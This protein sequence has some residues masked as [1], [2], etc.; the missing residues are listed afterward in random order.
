M[1]EHISSGKYR[2]WAG[3]MLFAL[4]L[5]WMAVPASAQESGSILGTV[6]DASG[7]TVPAAKITVTNADTNE[8]RTAN[9]G[10]DGAYR[11]PGLKP[12]NYTLKAE[13]D[14]FKTVT[15]MSLVLNVAS[16]IVVNPTMEVGSSTQEVTVTGEAPVINTTTS[17]L[18]NLINDQ[19][20]SQLPM[21]GRNYTDLTLLSPGIVQTTHSGLGDAGLWYSSN[22]APPRS[23]NYMLDGAVTVT[24]NGTGPSS[25][26]GATLGVD[27]IKEYKVVTSMFSAEYGLLMGS[28]MVIVSKS[29]TNTWHGSAFDYL[30]NNHLDARNFFDPQP[31]R[32]ESYFDRCQ[33]QPAALA[34][35]QAQQL[36]RLARRTHPE[37]QDVLLPGV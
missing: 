25:I 10:D 5:G 28:Q 27:G 11:V 35:I 16:E 17:S 2:M 30:R 8:T 34:A 19:T 12:G 9:T 36:R 22:G 14:G 3:V 6:R 24:K 7:G 31:N 4:I 32:S 13:K 18:G 37:G 1:F 21:N 20:I 29:G 15:Q 23:N 26:T 33:R